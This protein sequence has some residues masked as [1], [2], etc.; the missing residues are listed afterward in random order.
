MNN[1]ITTAK[2]GPWALITGGTS[3]IGR[4]LAE[5]LAEKGLNLVLVARRQQLLDKIS[6]KIADKYQVEVR[7]LKADLSDVASVEY[8]KEATEKLEI[9]LFIP[10]AGV[11]NHGEFVNGD[12]NKEM[13]L[14]QLN[15]VTPMQL[16]HH[17]GSKMKE[18]GKGGI[19]FLATTIGY[20][21]TPFFS[22]YAASKA[23]ILALG[24]GLHYELKKYGVDVT[25][26]SPGGTDTP[27][28]ENFGFDMK[29]LPMPM[30][31]P[32]ETAT[33]GLKALGSKPSVIPG[34]Q[35][36]MMAFMSKH[37][38]TRKAN[39]SMAGK[40]MEKLMSPEKEQEQL[41]RQ[42]PQL[43]TIEV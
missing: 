33:A 10:N 13:R 20:G 35:N 15:S 41:E 39:V 29:N 3:G 14:V 6:A 2:Y 7:G 30:M 5:Q 26:L 22:H 4:A 32:E 12:M 38:M 28:I 8:V 43:E 42:E 9:G 18:R 1:H 19:M 21:G 40:M 37:I 24:E 16:A 31:T 17:F 25:V 23:Y 34:F 11:E 36:N 27:M